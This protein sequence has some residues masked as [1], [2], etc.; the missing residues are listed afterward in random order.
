M[1]KEKTTTLRKPYYELADSVYSFSSET[2]NNTDK[3]LNDLTIELV[4]KLREIKNHLDKNY[5][6]V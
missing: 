6:W 3:K 5:I 2:H 4:G 1:T